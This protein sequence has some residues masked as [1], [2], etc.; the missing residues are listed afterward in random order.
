MHGKENTQ[1]DN[2][3]KEIQDV[4]KI[5]QINEEQLIIVN[6]RKQRKDQVQDKEVFLYKLYDISS[7]SSKPKTPEP[8]FI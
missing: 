7:K 2:H 5:E 4:Y 3:I 1:A 6:E 8:T